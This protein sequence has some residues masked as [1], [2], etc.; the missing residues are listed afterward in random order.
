MRETETSH[1]WV[2]H[3]PDALVAAYFAEVWDDDDED[4]EHTPL[5]AFARDQGVR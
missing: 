2:G 4:R 1:F 3:F 5:S